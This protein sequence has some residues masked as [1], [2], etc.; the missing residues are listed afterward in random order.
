MPAY[1]L[2]LPFLFVKFWYTEL[3]KG[4][5]FYFLSLNHALIQLFSIP[6]MLKTFFKPLKNEYREGLVV[7]SIC[8]GI[9]L[10]SILIF[11]GL[12]ALLVISIIEVGFLFFLLLWPLIT[13]VVLVT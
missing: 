2:E 11:V 1:V 5:F 12:F 9:V 10:K 6:V 7:F 3:P 8:M 4:L 13:I